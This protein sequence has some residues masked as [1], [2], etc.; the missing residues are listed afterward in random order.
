MLRRNDGQL[1]CLVICKGL[2]RCTRRY[3]SQRDVF[4]Q[5]AIFKRSFSSRRG[6]GF[7]QAQP[8]LGCEGLRSAGIIFDELRKRGIRGGFILQELQLPACN[9][10]QPFGAF[11]VGLR[12]HPE[13]EFNLFDG[14]I[15]FSQ[16]LGKQACELFAMGN[17]VGIAGERFGKLLDLREGR[18]KV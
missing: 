4:H 1:E 5:S 6:F 12:L 17:I 15:H 16:R 10:H 3:S 14:E 2:R 7:H 13:Q 18:I 8:A 9:E 11:Y